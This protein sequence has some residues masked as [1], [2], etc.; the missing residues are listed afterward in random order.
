MGLW[1]ILLTIFFIQANIAGVGFCSELH[2]EYVIVNSYPHDQKA[3]TQGFTFHNGFIYEGT[4]LYGQSS[5]RQV[6]LLDGIVLKQIDLPGE[7]FG[8]GI[9]IL[10]DRIYQLTW[11]EER[12]FVYELDSLVKLEEFYYSL[13]GWGLTTDGDLLIMSNGSHHLIF[14]DPITYKEK[15]KIEVLGESGFVVRLNELEYIKGQIFAN[16]WL[17]DLIVCIDPISGQVAGW[18]DLSYLTELERE[19]NPT[20]EVLNGIAYDQEGDRIFVT[21]KYWSKIY[22][23]RLSD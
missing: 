14:I 2:Y 20:A 13:E 3:F 4:G 1:F 10:R 16:I 12:G 15:Y 9:T 17:T 6:S 18:I 11:Q 22:E 5:L 21:G 23:I 19:D 8:E 7:Y